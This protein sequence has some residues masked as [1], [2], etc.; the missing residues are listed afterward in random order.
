MKQPIHPHAKSI[1]QLLIE[2]KTA[3]TG[4]TK[5]QITKLLKNNTNN[6]L[7]RSHNIRDGFG[8]FFSQ[9][10]SPLITILLVAGG[11]SGLLKEYI[12]SA[13]IIGTAFI[14]ILVGFGQEFKANKAISELSKL[15]QQF[16][17]VIRDNNKTRIDSSNIIVGDIVYLE[18]GMS[19][20]ADG[21]IIESNYLEVDESPL[22]G[23]SLPIKK[24]IKVLSKN[25]D[26]TDQTNMV[27]KGTRVTSGTGLFVVTAIGQHT[28]IGNIANLVSDVNEGL[29]PLQKQVFTLSKQIG[30][31]IGV[32][33][34]LIFAIGLFS[35]GG[36]SHA[37]IQLFETAVAVAVAAIPEGLVISLTIILAIGMRFMAKKKALVRIL[38]AA[39]TLGSVNVIC[40]DKTGT[41]TE[42][43]MAVESFEFLDR[44]VNQY[45]FD[46]LDIADVKT[47]SDIQ[48][49]LLISSLSNNAVFD[50]TT[51]DYIGDT[52][53]IAFANLSKSLGYSKE[54]LEKLYTNLDS[55][56]FSSELK[57]I[58]SLNNFE[59][60]NKLFI[61]GASEVLLEKSDFILNNNK[62]SKITRQDKIY[63]ESLVKKYASQGYRVIA[64]ATK[65]VQNKTLKD[66]DSN[67]L[68][69]I[70]IAVISDP[71]RIGVSNVLLKTAGAGIRTVM[72][73]GDYAQ[74][75]VSIAKKIGLPHKKHNVITG[76]ELE[77][78][79]DRELE[80]IINDISIF[81]RANPSHKMRIVAALQKRGNVVAMTGDGVNDAPA[82]KLADIGI[83]VGSG[84]DVAK[85]TADMVLLDD[86]LQTIVDAIEH[87][88][89]IYENIRKVILYLFSGTFA[90]VIL[91]TTM[92]VIGYPLP[93]IPAQILWINVIEDTFPNI[94]L[95]FDAGD[96]DNMSMNPRKSSE[97]LINKR[98]K[99]L[100]VSKTVIINI[101]LILL[102]I[103]MLK[104]TN[105]LKLARTMMF[106]GFGID[107]LFSIF[108]IRHMNHLIWTRN[109]FDNRYVLGAVALGWILLISAVHVPFL[110]FVLMTVDLS[111]IYWLVMIV[112]GLF[113]LILLECV[114]LLIKKFKL[115]I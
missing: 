60:T 50:D 6:D 106:V 43:K 11:I 17:I 37:I 51:Q 30:I 52:T 109:N 32:I 12:D 28:V 16:A 63:F 89:G 105:D 67:G 41:I 96:K 15:V 1:S 27:F 104:T 56:P 54:R 18:A 10:K 82:I 78:M 22:T 61:K 55:I 83:A 36:D 59:K 93:A 91:V 69:F 111:P 113:N 46:Q 45:G 94:A 20:P 2:L 71:V 68:I 26:Y 100:I 70:G 84:T 19:V 44:T 14:N 58:G 77:K 29:T 62:I 49:A 66:I 64:L 47:G 99:I 97:A 35:R 48:L 88:R 31:I 3:K 79:S 101:I 25:I 80:K 8:L 92:L 42:G 39:E 4:L 23:E 85:Q 57:Y 98:M 108:S 7:P 38:V 86:S 115:A 112:F 76:S 33:A 110:Q 53:D 103:Y 114:K 24:N 5:T 107:A 90:E 13:V 65:D 74:T 87:G 40:T 81:A 9:F 95:A 72:I 102:F 21:R 34:L 73:T 75:A